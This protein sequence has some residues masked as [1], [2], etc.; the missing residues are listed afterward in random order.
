M[1]KHPPK[2]SSFALQHSLFT[3]SLQNKIKP[4]K[5]NAHNTKSKLYPKTKHIKSFNTD[6]INQPYNDHSKKKKKTNRERKGNNNN[7]ILPSEGSVL[8]RE[9]GRATKTRERRIERGK[10]AR[11]IAVRS[12]VQVRRGTCR[13]SWR[14][15]RLKRRKRRGEWG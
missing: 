3:Q 8:A 10:R 13:V 12:V 5:P 2:T 9:R 6:H 7:D 11:A 1:K 15:K 14:R 4:P